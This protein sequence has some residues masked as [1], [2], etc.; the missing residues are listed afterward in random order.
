LLNTVELARRLPEEERYRIPKGTVGA[1]VSESAQ[2]A[3]PIVGRI[4]DF[5]EQ[6]SLQLSNERRNERTEGQQEE[7][8]IQE[9]VKQW[10]DD[11]GWLRND[12]GIYNDTALFSQ[13]RLTAHGAYELASHVSLL[14]RLSGGEFVLDAASGPIAHPEY[15]AYSWFYKYHVCVDFSQTA[16]REAQAKLEGKGFSC[17]ANICQLPFRE[18]VFDGIVSGYTLQHIAESQQSKAVTELYRVLKPGSHLCVISEVRQ[19]RAHR[20]LV[21]ALRAIRKV[22][23]LLSIAGMRTNRPRA[24]ETSAFPKPPHELYCRPRY[25]AWWRKQGQSLTDFYVLEGLRLF[26]KEE[27]GF[28]FG[29]SMRAAKSVRAVEVLFPGLAARMCAYLLVDFSKPLD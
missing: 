15:L 1:F 14:N 13:N 16:L 3:Y 26:N 2:T 20:M 29:N 25:P 9:S 24:A 6:D 23:R 27:F 21:L 10:Y 19:T 8:S 5:L 4:V 11:F 18:G 12:S 7:L 17:M 22:L 28:F